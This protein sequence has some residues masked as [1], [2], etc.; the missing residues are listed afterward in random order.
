MDSVTDS[1]H[2]GDADL[3]AKIKQWFQWDKNETTL[4]EMKNLLAGEKY[5]EMKELVSKR[6]EFGTAGLRAAMGAGFC[7]MNDVTVIQASQGVCKYLLSQF[8]DLKQRG[9]VVGFDARHNSRR[10]VY[11]VRILASRDV[12]N[13]Q[14]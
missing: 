13:V 6:M 12:K 7:K 11:F 1:I 5:S 3:D 2:S 4:G 14:G 8:S 9:F 10:F